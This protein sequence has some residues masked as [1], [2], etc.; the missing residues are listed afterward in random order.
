MDANAHA[1]KNAR[2]KQKEEDDKKKAKQ[3]LAYAAPKTPNPGAHDSEKPPKTPMKKK[4]RF[5]AELAGAY[6][7]KSP[8]MT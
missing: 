5:L 2:Q 1:S 3:T 8:I 4:E 6:S 7:P